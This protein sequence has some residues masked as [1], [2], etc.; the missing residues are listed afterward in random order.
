M[1]T[2]EAKDL[3]VC[4][5]GQTLISGVSFTLQAGDWLCVAGPNGA[6]KSTLL[7]ALIGEWPHTGLLS[8]DAQPL[9]GFRP[10]ERARLLGMMGQAS[11]GQFSFTVEE[12]VRMGRYPYRKSLLRTDDPGGKKAVED[13]LQAAGLTGLRRR[14]VTTL[15]GGERQRCALAQTLCQQPEVLLLDEPSNHLDLNYQKELYQITDTWRRR[16]GHAVITVLHDLSAARRFATKAL[17]L[18]A[19]RPL[20]F[21]P[22]D[23]ALSDDALRDAWQMDVSAWMREM[24]GVWT[25]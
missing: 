3:G 15:S 6:G 10:R 1:Q 21:G 19:G 22:P 4:R 11:F 7:K 16:P 24:A 25:R 5:N 9:S 12:V 18:S 20:T 14:S 13:A 23:E 8:L 17:L 2:I